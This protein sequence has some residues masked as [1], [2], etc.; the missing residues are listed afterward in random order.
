MVLSIVIDNEKR[1]WENSSLTTVTTVETIGNN[2][3]IAKDQKERRFDTLK[4]KELRNRV[5][6]Q[7]ARDSSDVV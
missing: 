6:R 5:C 1:Q 7:E 4:E 3:V 2:S